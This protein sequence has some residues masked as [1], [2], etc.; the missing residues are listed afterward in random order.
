MIWPYLTH[1][2]ILIGIYVILTVSLNLALG[3]TGLLN[4]GHVAFFGIG[5]YTS[6]LLTKAGVPFLLAFIIAGIFASIFGYL[7]VLATRKLKGDYLALA[8]LGFSFVIYS[9][10]LNWTGLTRG[11]LGIPGIEK[12]SF[13][14]LTISSTYS[15]LIFVAVIC[16]LSVFVI[17][18]IVKSPFGRLLEATRDDEMGLR[19]LGKNTFKL[20]YKAMMISAFFAGIAGSLFAHYITYIDPSYFTI[21]E[22]ILLL[23]IVIVGGIASIKGSIVSTFVILLIP[24]A[25]RFLALSSSILGP[26]RQVIYAM[27]LLGILLLRPRGIFGRVDLE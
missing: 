17:Y 8:T 5:A 22:I 4:L 7:L 1:L 19:V 13:F 12:P 9:L 16:I 6:A 15:Y 27:I 26:A 3:Y 11:P 25:L 10:M 24:E 18:R 20:K 14:G 21:P 23:S 2:L